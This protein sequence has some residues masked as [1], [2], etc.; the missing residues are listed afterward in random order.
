M[1]IVHLRARLSCKQG[2]VGHLVLSMT[3]CA[4]TAASSNGSVLEEQHA[5]MDVLVTTGLAPMCRPRNW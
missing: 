3:W 1:V 4:V 2:T 5:F